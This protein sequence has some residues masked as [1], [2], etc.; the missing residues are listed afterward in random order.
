MFKVVL[1][2]LATT[3]FAKHINKTFLQGLNL[4]SF[5]I[6]SEANFLSIVN[7]TCEFAYNVQCCLSCSPRKKYLRKTMIKALRYFINQSKLTREVLIHTFSFQKRGLLSGTVHQFDPIRTV[8][9]L[10]KAVTYRVE[11]GP[12]LV[13][14]GGLAPAELAHELDARRVNGCVRRRGAEKVRI[15]LLIRQRRSHASVRYLLNENEDLLLLH[16]LFGQF[17]PEI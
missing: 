14:G 1:C 15:R 5:M 9:Y 6:K 7:V 4:G 12:G 16:L 2:V 11:D 10:T 8:I 17:P 13:E 3:N